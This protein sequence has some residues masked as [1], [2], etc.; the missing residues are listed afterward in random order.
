MGWYDY[1]ANQSGEAINIECDWNTGNFTDTLQPGENK[2]Y[3]NRG[4]GCLYTFWL[5]G[6]VV[7]NFQV[8]DNRCQN[9]EFLIG[10]GPV[11]ENMNGYTGRPP[12]TIQQQYPPTSNLEGAFIGDEESNVDYSEQR[13]MGSD[14]AAGLGATKTQAMIDGDSCFKDILTTAVAEAGD[15]KVF[16][17]LLNGQ[18]NGRNRHCNI[19]TC[20]TNNALS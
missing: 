1:F 10:S 5:N 19:S 9:W 4:A 12:G 17:A 3:G 20:P 2:S 18:P 13:K 14:V 7:K 11:V 16:A 15:E 6:N 8:G